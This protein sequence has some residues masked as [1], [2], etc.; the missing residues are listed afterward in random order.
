M[1]LDAHATNP[2]TNAI[3]MARCAHFRL[4][5]IHVAQAEANN[6][7]H[8]TGTTHGVSTSDRRDTTV[9]DAQGFSV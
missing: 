2:Q 9:F 8:T 4:V 5:S 7:A 1:F 6:P 3:T